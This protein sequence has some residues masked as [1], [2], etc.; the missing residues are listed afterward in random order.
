MKVLFL[1]QQANLEPWFHDVV[2]AIGASHQVDL[3]DPRL[4]L[5]PQLAGAAVVVDQGGGVGTHATMD[6]AAAAGIKLWQVLGTGLDHVDVQYILDRGLAL[7]NTPG[8]FSSIALAEHAMFLMLYFAKQFP[9]MQQNVRGGRFYQPMNEELDG[10]TLGILGL[11]A[12]GR[13]LAK[14]A[15]AFGMRLIGL[16]AEPPPPEILADLEVTYLGTAES[17]NRVLSDSDYVS[18]HVPLTRRTRHLIDAD[19]LARMRPGSILINVARGELV[20]E[21]A[22]IHALRHGP[23]GGAG[24]DVFAAEPLDPSSPLLELNNVVL[25]PHVAGVTTGTSRRR[26]AAVAENVHRV[27]AGLPPLYSVTKAE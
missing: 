13:E 8:P 9:S 7:A 24:V 4:P 21:A 25:T 17:L 5:A 16:D 10:K 20:D 18:L 1:G 15:R 11:G 23:L 22:L 27:A 19:A 3:Y 14:R 12:S 2:A 26:A 6:A